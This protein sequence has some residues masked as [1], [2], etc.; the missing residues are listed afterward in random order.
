MQGQGWSTIFGPPSTLAKLYSYSQLLSDAPQLKL[1]AYGAVHAPHLPIPE[2]DPI[3]GNSPV[4]SRSL[5]PRFLIL[6]SSSC[7]PFPASNLRSLLI[8]IM[9]DILQNTLDM[10]GTIEASLSNISKPK[11][12]NI[13]L[14]VLGTAPHEALVR[15]ALK[16]RNI[17]VT[18]AMQASGSSS[19]ELRGGSD[20][21]AIVGMSGR[22]PGSD[23]IASY[24]ETLL[25]GQDFHKTVSFRHSDDFRKFAESESR[26][27]VIVLILKYT[28]IPQE[29]F[30]TPLLFHMGAGSTIRDIL[31]PGFSTSL[32]EKH[33]RWIQF[34]G[35]F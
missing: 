23:N 14:C 32:R 28:M 10:Q 34:R 18:M 29:V 4:L 30:R 20:L 9:P 2:L 16:A 21:V 19:S 31:M 11:A 33:F 25:N 27:L 15:T 8:Q 1:R 3:I 12:D 13:R 35:S 7:V 17:E 22:F 24:W 26:S 6:S 5:K